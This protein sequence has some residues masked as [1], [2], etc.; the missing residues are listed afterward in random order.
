MSHATHADFEL[1]IRRSRNRRNVLLALASLSLTYRGPLAQAAGVSFSQLMGVLYGSPGTY[2][3]GLALVPL[4]LAREVPGPNGRAIEIT[5]RGRRKAR[6][7]TA[8][9]VREG[10]KRRAVKREVYGQVEAMP[11]APGP[12]PAPAPASTCTFTF[13]TLHIP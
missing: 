5:E 13:S 8:R 4:G 11:T 7:L 12:S 2:R 10:V 3:P 6:Q 1:S 9:S